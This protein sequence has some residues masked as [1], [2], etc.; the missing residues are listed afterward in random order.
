MERTFDTL[1][2]LC[3]C[4]CVEHLAYLNL[5][6]TGNV[7]PHA[8]DTPMES[9]PSL[10]PNLCNELLKKYLNCHV[11]QTVVVNHCPAPAID[12]VLSSLLKKATLKETHLTLLRYGILSDFMLR[13]ISNSHITSLNLLACKKYS[14]ENKNVEMLFRKNRFSIRNLKL[15]GKFDQL[16]DEK[17]LSLYP[18]L[19]KEIENTQETE[20]EVIGRQD[21]RTDNETGSLA[22]SKDIN[23]NDVSIKQGSSN[24]SETTH[25]SRISD[26]NVQCGTNN[27]CDSD[28]TFLKE[29]HW[30]KFPNMQ[31][32]TL[33]NTDT[34]PKKQ[35]EFIIGSF[36][37]SNP[38][39]IA[40][41]IVC[42]DANGLLPTAAK[43]R[44]LT[45]LC[46]S[47]SKHLQTDVTFSL[48][49]LENL[50]N[51]RHL[52]VSSSTRFTYAAEDIVQFVKYVE[53]ASKLVSL[54]LGGTNLSLIIG[55][56]KFCL[57]NLEFRY[58]VF[59]Q[60]LHHHLY[61]NTFSIV[62]NLKA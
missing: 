41:C 16:M 57:E 14:F 30:F 31:S 29:T 44:N 3:I 58:V 60:C 37:A 35:S 50:D 15:Y 6:G 32:V 62:I 59:L 40:V 2:D 55:H 20:T 51:L 23:S 34:W 33:V 56:E 9:S 25:I 48:K 54:E 45:S 24:A 21:R 52:D 12:S 42:I 49:C 5:D 28:N 39:L 27:A 4:Y 7:N 8:E 10:S 11:T 19:E 53:S 61:E 22:K 1:Q 13:N 38:Q 47:S 46:L 26:E 43:L 36:L 18:V 17:H